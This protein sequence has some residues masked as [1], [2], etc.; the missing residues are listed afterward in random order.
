F[1]LDAHLVVDCDAQLLLATEV[2]LCCLDRDVSKQELDLVQFAAGEM[3]EPGATP[4]TMPH[5]A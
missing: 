3:T 2:T 1:W 5:T 4:P